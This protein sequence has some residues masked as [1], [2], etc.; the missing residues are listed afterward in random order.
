MPTATSPPKRGRKPKQPALVEPVQTT[1]Q[2]VRIP[3]TELHPFPDHPF[4]IREDQAMQDTADSVKQNGV[5]VPAIVRP[6]A[7]GEYEIVA[8]HRR[9]LASEQAGFTDMPCII[10]NLT[11][12]EAIIQLVD[13]NAQ[14]EDVLPSERAKAYK[15]Q[16]LGFLY[17]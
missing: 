4:G 10:R 12:D 6:R 14:R 8:G 11:D 1:E 7:E 17:I 2:I 3:L 9:K 16:S 15:T 13:S 5:V